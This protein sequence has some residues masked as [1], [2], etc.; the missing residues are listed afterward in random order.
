MY[1][2]VSHSTNISTGAFI[3]TSE[4][5]ASNLKTAY[6][7]GSALPTTA[8]EAPGAGTNI[9]SFGQAGGNFTTC[10][11]QEYIYWNLEQSTNRVAIETLINDYYGIF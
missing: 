10:Q 7:N 9:N 5:N 2:T 4:K 1:S 3:M 6:L 8:T 11:Y